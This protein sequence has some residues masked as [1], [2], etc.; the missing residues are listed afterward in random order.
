M[1]V[2]INPDH[3]KWA[4]EISPDHPKWAKNLSA[5]WNGC[6]HEDMQQHWMENTLCHWMT[7]H[8]GTWWF[9]LNDKLILLLIKTNRIPLCHSYIH[10][11]MYVY[12]YTYIYIHI[13]TNA[14]W[15]HCTISSLMLGNK[16]LLQR[17]HLPFTT[18]DGLTVSQLWVKQPKECFILHLFSLAFV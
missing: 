15:P 11:P 18:L 3:P 7:E 16:H 14:S 4:V 9:H 6:V 5:D 13:H 12:V 1:T 17:L 2:E 8:G 10:G